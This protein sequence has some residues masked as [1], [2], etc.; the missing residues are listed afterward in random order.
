MIKNK[1]E[2]ILF[3]SNKPLSVKQL[4]DLVD[5]GK[6]ETETV[7]ESLKEEY[8]KNNRGIKIIEHDGKIQMATD[9]G[10]SEV[11]QKFLKQELTG[12]MTRPQLE[13]LTI[14][15]YRGP[16][17]KMELEQI[18]GV[19]CSLILRNLQIRGLIEA[20]LDKRIKT[21]VYNV[22]P[23]FVRFLG[24]TNI[25]QLPDYEKLSNHETIESLINQ[26]K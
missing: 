9:D 16:I 17:T 21:T 12:E 10:S 1:I 3:I 11:I 15:A 24:I 4:A 22:T 5:I 25:S 13:A 19:N 7:L 6:V 26:N 14:I 20:C 18:R 2:S 23:D 8:N